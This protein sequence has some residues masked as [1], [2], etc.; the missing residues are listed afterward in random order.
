MGAGDA[1]LPVLGALGLL[2]LL[3]R[4]A[5]TLGRAVLTHLLAERG[6]G[7]ELASFG[8]WAVVT[9]ATSGIGRAYAHELAKRGLNVVLISRSLQKLKLVAAEIEK[10]HGRSTRVIEVDF[11]QESEI[12][13]SIQTALQG[14]DIGILVNNVGMFY[15]TGPVKFLDIPNI[16]KTVSDFV[17]CN[18]LSVAKM[19]RIVLPQMLTRKKGIIINISSE[20]GRRPQPLV[21]VYSATKRFVDFF[22]R[23]LEAEYCSQGILVQSVLPFFVSTNMTNYIKPSRFV[24]TA[25]TFA[26]EAL[27]TVGISSRT[28][29]C[30]SHSVQSFIYELLYP[31]WLC[32][33]S[34]GIKCTWFLWRK[35]KTQMT[36]LK[37]EQARTHTPK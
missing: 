4:A 10:Q 6:R 20:T 15:A 3:L 17:N 28:S 14:L 11:T 18:M 13:E 30:L 5:W 24:K 33:S 2:L 7:A 8:A 1:G 21:T 12:Y 23:G 9:G 37:H 35:L 25:E 26:C 19:T 29:G 32:L 27:N 16:E 36:S 31:E 34:F 22:S